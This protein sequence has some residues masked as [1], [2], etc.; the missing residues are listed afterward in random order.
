MNCT[1]KHHYQKDE[2]W[3]VA[4]LSGPY[5]KSG[6]WGGVMGNIVN[7]K[8]MMSLSAWVWNFEREDL[9]DFVPGEQKPSKNI[10]QNKA[11]TVTC[12]IL[13]ITVISDQILLAITPKYPNYDLTLFI[14]PFTNEAWK[15]IG[16]TII[17]IIVL[18]IG[19]YWIINYYEF[20]QG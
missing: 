12:D 18:I 6:V 2:F 3:G 8:Y 13:L 1:L 11:N 17:V 14:R 5:N 19:P 4:P 15:Y 16:I 10:K 7:G 20:T 9:A